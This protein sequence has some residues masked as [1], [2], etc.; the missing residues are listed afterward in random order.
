[1][2]VVQ[3]TVD[4]Q[5]GLSV[6][7]PTFLPS[8]IYDYRLGSREEWEQSFNIGIGVCTDL[9]WE[10]LSRYVPAPCTCVPIA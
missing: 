5:G 7:A 9:Q 3:G 8:K 2:R 1:M 10:G 6:E 4:F